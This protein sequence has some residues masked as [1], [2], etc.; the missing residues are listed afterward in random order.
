MR[1]FSDA[2]LEDNKRNN[3]RIVIISMRVKTS[4]HQEDAKGSKN[5]TE[6]EK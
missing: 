2:I 4:V 6:T 5:K 1:Y 3:Q